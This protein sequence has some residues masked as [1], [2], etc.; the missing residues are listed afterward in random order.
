MLPFHAPW[1]TIGQDVMSSL[2]IEGLLD[3][4]VRREEEVKEDDGWDEEG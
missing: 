1:Y 2:Y 3:L 4:S